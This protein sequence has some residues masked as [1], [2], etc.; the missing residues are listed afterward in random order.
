VRRRATGGAALLA[1]RGFLVFG[2]GIGANLLLAG[3]LDPRDFGLVA[4]GSVLL[5]FGGE[6]AAGG[7]GVALVR[8]EEPPT[9]RELEAVDA[10][11]LLMTAALAL[12]VTVAALP[13]GRDGLVVAT[14]VASLPITI[15]RATSV[16]VLERRLSYRAIAT[17]DVLDAVS[18]Y[19]W[20]I[21]T[22]ALGMG[23]WGM[24]T[25]MVFRALVGTVAMARLGPLGFVRPR[26]SWPAVRP[27]LGFGVKLQ[28]ISI[29]GV[30]R[31]QGINIGTAALGSVATLGAW[32]LAFRVLQAPV[33]VFAAVTR[34]SYPA[35][36]RLLA[37][38]RD[39]RGAIE[40]GLANLTVATALV[41]VAIAGFAPALPALV[42]HDWHQVPATL[43]A[44]CAAIIVGAPVYVVTVGYL[45]ATDRAGAV[46]R[47]LIAYTLT[48]FAVTFPLVPV[49]GAPA[50]GVGWIAGSFVNATLLGRQAQRHTGAAIAASLLPAAT[51]AT[52]AGAIGW[53]VGVAGH[54]TVLHGVLGAAAGEAAL[55]AGLAV[56][57]R[58][59]LRDAWRVLLEAGKGATA[60]QPEV[61]V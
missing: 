52:I 39:P 3:L 15:V 37:A 25:G 16:I 19:A 59:L 22:V 10:V 49:L 43:A 4:V 51:I 57:R 56:V 45:Y 13:F 40:G 7:L 28:A 47:S 53:A 29:V 1:A 55:I 6:L 5:V 36:S 2:L 20:S 54:S 61:P 38:G 12:L 17:V 21:T 41:L 42:G 50:I 58:S 18:F 11:Q 14:M 34:V 35:M 9:Q 33:L 32:N 8:R 31:E 30:I 60:P 23:V 24:A 48:W 26:W 27:L 46:V 44:A